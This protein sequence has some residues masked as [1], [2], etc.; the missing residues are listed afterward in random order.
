MKLCIF[1]VVLRKL[2]LQECIAA[3]MRDCSKQRDQLQRTN[4]GRSW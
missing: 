1:G 2:R 4:G 3:L